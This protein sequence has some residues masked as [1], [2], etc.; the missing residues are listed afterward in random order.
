MSAQT[1]TTTTTKDLGIIYKNCNHPIWDDLLFHP[2]SVDKDRYNIITEPSGVGGESICLKKGNNTLDDTTV[3]QIRTVTEQ[4]A[5]NNRQFISAVKDLVEHYV[6]ET[7]NLIGRLRQTPKVSA[8]FLDAKSSDSTIEIEMGRYLRGLQQDLSSYSNQ[9]ARFAHS[10]T[11]ALE[12]PLIDT[13][14]KPF[15]RLVSRL[16]YAQRF[17]FSCGH[18]IAEYPN[19]QPHQQHHSCQQE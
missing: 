12:A 17:T 14:S 9:M 8:P 13:F 19:S 7:T 11:A 5:Q 4:I 6:S 2:D 15:A 18:I 10:I 1:T 3:Y 16:S